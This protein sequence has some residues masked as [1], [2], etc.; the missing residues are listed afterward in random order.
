MKPG[1]NVRRVTAIVNPVSR[2]G[3]GAAT[4]A[5]RRA[6]PPDV[7][8]DV[9]FS[10]RTGD[11]VRLAREAARISRVVVAVGGDGTV[12]DVATGLHGAGV[13]LG[14]VPAGST[15]I[16]ARDL[17]IPTDFHAAAA[18]VFQP[19]RL[20]RV[21]VGR[22]GDRS[23][24][25]MAGAGLD[26]RFFERTDR[27]LK[28]RLGW[29]AYLPAAAVSLRLPPARFSITADTRSIDVT[30]SLVLVANGGSIVVPGLRLHPAISRS[31]GWL[32][33]LV[34]TAI[35]PLPIARTLSSLAAG[36]LG[37][38]P[39]LVWIKAKRVELSSDP[40]LPLQLD[41]DVV[42]NT[43]AVLTVEPDALTIIQ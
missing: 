31:D 30:S 25:H 34:F 21:D 13:P 10:A 38:S 29:L 18:L 11:G 3:A 8:L 35:A 24:L 12:A 32:D 23:F 36:R 15:N 27:S 41:G 5:L 43:P 14:I 16:I 9:Q 39:Y 1:Q 4:D 42:T 7:D 6:A 28:R 37:S 33:L 22:C 26:G 17:G 2:R 19:R 40:P 20:Q